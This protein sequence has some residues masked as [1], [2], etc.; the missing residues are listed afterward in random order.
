MQPHDI[1]FIHPG[2][3]ATV[4]FTA[5]D[6]SI[7]GGLDAKVE[8]ISPDTIVDER[9]NAFYLVR[10]RTTQ[11]ELQR[12]DADHPRHDR[13]G[14]RPDRQQ[15]GAVVP[16]QAGAEGARLRAERTLSRQRTAVE[17][18]G[19][20]SVTYLTPCDAGGDAGRS[21]GVVPASISEGEPSPEICSRATGLRHPR[22]NFLFIQIRP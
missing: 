7:Y 3:K 12:Q 22:G 2:Q 17:P 11:A 19:Q 21:S 9:G 6:F 16:A 5:Y 1:A 10:V 18:A 14:R 13:R 15:D 4:K 20:Q 8:N